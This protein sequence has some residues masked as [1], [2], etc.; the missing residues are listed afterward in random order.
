MNTVDIAG[1]AGF[2]L[3]VAGTGWM[4]PPAGLIVAGVLLLTAA[5]IASSRSAAPKQDDK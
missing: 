4:Y 5:V 1:V 3:L 2:V